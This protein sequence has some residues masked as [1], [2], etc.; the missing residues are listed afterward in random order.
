MR[1]RI[2]NTVA[3]A[4]HFICPAGA[5]LQMQQ[6]RCLRHKTDALNPDAWH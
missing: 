6:Y 1:F 4:V 2:G 5:T 3:G